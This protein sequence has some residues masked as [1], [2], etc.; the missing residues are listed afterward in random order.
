M[1]LITLRQPKAVKRQPSDL[2]LTF[3]IISC[4]Q[5]PKKQQAMIQSFVD[6]VCQRMKAKH[7]NLYTKTGQNMKY[8]DT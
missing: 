6:T 7:E 3:L 1:A 8:L 4:P 2:H 5:T